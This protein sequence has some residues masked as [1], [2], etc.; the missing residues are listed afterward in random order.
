MLLWEQQCNGVARWLTSELRLF[1]QTRMATLGAMSNALQFVSI[2]VNSWM[3]TK[4]P[5][6]D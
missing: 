5:N 6:I 2:R 1:Q 4:C 3:K